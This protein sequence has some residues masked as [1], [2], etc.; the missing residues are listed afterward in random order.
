MSF[1]HLVM[2]VGLVG[3]HDLVLRGGQIVDGSGNPWFVGDVAVTGGVIVEIA[4][5]I[6]GEGDREIDASG[7]VVAPGFIDLHTHANRG[8]FTDPSAEFF[9]RQ[10]VTT[11]FEGPDG[12][13]PLPIGPFLERIAEADPAPNFGTFVGHGSIRGDVMGQDDRAPTDDELEAMRELVRNAMHEGAFGLSSGL[14]YTP[15]AFA[16]TEEVIELAKVAGEMGGIYISHM[17]DEMGGVVDSV[18]ETIRIG[19]EGGLPAQIT[20]H[21]VIGRIHEGLG[22]E[23]LE[24]IDAARERGVDVSSDLYPYTA[25]STGLGSALLPNWANDGGGDA[26]RERLADPATR[27]TIREYVIERINRERGAGDP[28]TIQIASAE[29]DRELEGKNLT[30]IMIERGVEPTVEN[31]ADLALEMIGRGHV[32]AIYHAIS[33]P[34]LE[35]IL[36]HPASMI[37]SDGELAIPG[38]GSPHPRC[39]GTFPRVLAVYV[40][41]KG[42]LT[43]EDAI[44]KMTSLPAQRV[45]L[46][47]R[48]IL[49]PGLAADI[50]LFDPDTIRDRATFQE[51][52]QYAIGVEYVLINGTLVLDN[53]EMT[54]ARPG[55][56]LRGPAAAAER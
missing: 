32:S 53:G 46:F 16:T 28:S 40:R 11:I 37:A 35:R 48:G 20:H 23:S 2:I 44:R 43:L 41:E 21:K 27:A 4:P 56:V 9:I 54:D 6:E 45:G 36:L 50:V 49:R 14:F 26:M 25:S 30:E 38:K 5:H 22:T 24:L 7:L 3:N 17:R 34:D 31:A 51:P 8:I 55:T 12:S 19:E 13:S 29:A 15:G 47:D 18:K 39:C 10:G 42:L 33:E 52:H 1:L